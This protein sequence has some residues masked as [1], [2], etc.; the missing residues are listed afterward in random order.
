MQLKQSGGNKTFLP[1]LQAYTD[2]SSALEY[3][4]LQVK[5][6]IQ[7][8]EEVDVTGYILYNEQGNYPLS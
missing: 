5:E 3:T 4:D 7:A 2:P 8:L 6:Q 1:M